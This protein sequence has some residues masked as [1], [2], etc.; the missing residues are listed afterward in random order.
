MKLI[1]TNFN[2]RNLKARK[3]QQKQ[4]ADINLT[5]AQDQTTQST[6]KQK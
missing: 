5:P 1:Q 2:Q 4:I 3:K 6:V